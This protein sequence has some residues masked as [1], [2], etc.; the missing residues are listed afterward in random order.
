MKQFLPVFLFL[1]VTSSSAWAQNRVIE[2]RV[3]ALEDGQPLPGVNVLIPGTTKGVA[4]D[5][6]GHY[7]I[8][9]APGENTLNFS[10]IGYKT[11]SV[12]VGERTSVD[13]V[14]EL[15]SKTLEEVVVVGYGAQKKSDITG[16]TANVKGDE[17]YKQPVLTATQAVQGKIAGVQI[18]S[19]G[20]PGSSPQIRVRGVSTA[21]GATT[22]LY[23]VDGVLTDD[24]SNVNTA[25]II[26]MNVLKDASAAAIYG[27]RGANGVVIITTRKG[28]S[29]KMKISYN[30]NVGFR[31]AANLVQMA[32]SAE[33]SNYVQAATGTIPPA[34][35]YNTNWYKT[36]LRNAFEQ[37]HNVS[38][39][40][41][42]EKSTFLLNAGYLNDQGIII[43]NIFKRL[44]LRL[45]N[46]YRFNDK[47]KFGMQSSYSNSNNQNGFGNIEYRY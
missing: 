30:N 32:S 16:A 28:S 46:E 9:L 25:D 24:I 4:T 26:D 8:E 14:L 12:T 39:S 27:S 29:G 19:S 23:V 47:L 41:G 21:L 11:Q 7:H 10:F 44:T 6:E 1:F 2:G 15:E 3:T 20:Q 31:Q 42:T 36:I 33:Y 45:N 17:L 22:T 38:I 35:S 40:G 5:V 37:N 43:D 13:V 34:S 18:I